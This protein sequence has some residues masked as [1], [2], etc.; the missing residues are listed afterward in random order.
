[1]L[2]GGSDAGAHLD[3][4]CGAGY[5]TEFL[6]DCLRGR[7][8]LGLEAAVAAMSEAPARLFGLDGR[9]RLAEGYHADIVLFDPDKVGSTAAT[10]VKDLPGG[11]PRL[12]VGST[13]VEG[14]W[15]NGTRTIAS[16]ESTGALPGTTLRSGRDTSSVTCH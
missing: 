1:V 16:G 5:P 14:V 12:V 8:I 9:G 4:M 7:G 6:A 10:L 2:L 15:V 13:G 11:A 3:R